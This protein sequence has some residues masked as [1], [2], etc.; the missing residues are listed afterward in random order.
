MTTSAEGSTRSTAAELVL[1]V[2]T[3]LHSPVA[4]ALDRL[5]RKLGALAVPATK[6]GYEALVCWA[7]GF[8]DV[9]CAG[10]EE[11]GSFGAGLSRHLRAGGIEVLEVERPKRRHLRRKG[12]SDPIDAEAAARAVL[13]GEAAGAPKSG[14]GPVEMIR[15]IRAAAALGREGQDPGR[16]P[17]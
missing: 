12:K 16:E 5:G 7:E 11:T 9:R 3:H 17:A 14:D 8:G 15:A 4:V 6:K 10:I 2:D 1:G 13:A